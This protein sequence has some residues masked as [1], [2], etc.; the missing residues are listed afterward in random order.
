MAN[1]NPWHGCVKHSAGCQNCYVYRGDAARGRDASQVFRTHSFYDPVVRRRDGG[2][3]IP[4]GETVWTCF[5]SDFFLDLADPWREEAWD[6]MRRR[7][8]LDFF[9]ITKRIERLTD[10]L[11]PDWG[12]GWP[13]VAI[14]C[15]LENQDRAEFRLPLYRAAPIQRKSLACEP[16]LGPL[17]LQPWLGP[18][19]EKV[20]AGG[21]SGPN[22]RPCHYEWITA[23][24]E[25]CAAAEVPF[26]FKQT[27]ANF[28]KNGRLYRIPRRYQHIQARRADLNY[29]CR[30]FMQEAREPG[31]EQL[32]LDLEP[33]KKG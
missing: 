8:D 28:V 7:P 9:L 33:G 15:T 3:R 23:L 13:H 22:A 1:W 27:G 19:L 25:Q 31:P 4:P 30:S 6:M 16:L 12:A 2:W 20:V 17:E 24:R 11:P 26:F 18:W 10:C 29:K 21:E 5:S 32:T 14:C